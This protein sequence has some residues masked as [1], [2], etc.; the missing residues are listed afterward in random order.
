MTTGGQKNGRIPKETG[1]FHCHEPCRL[2]RCLSGTRLPSE[3]R[4]LPRYQ[5]IN[6]LKHLLLST[7]DVI[8]G[9]QI[10]AV[11]D[12]IR[13]AAD[14]IITHSALSLIHLGTYL[15]RVERVREL[16]L[17]DAVISK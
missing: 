13:R 9:H 2:R 11:D 10:L 4:M 8:R 1:H 6:H 5:E 12:D 16:F 3:R 15:K 17:G 14:L 7:D